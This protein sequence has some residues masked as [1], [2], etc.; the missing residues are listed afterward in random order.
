MSVYGYL[1]TDGAAAPVRGTLVADSPR[2]ARD[3]LREQGLSIHELSDGSSHSSRAMHWRL[4]LL[5]IGRRPDTAGFLRELATLLEVGAPMLESLDTVTRSTRGGFRLTLLRLREEVAAGRS[6]AEAMRDAR[7]AGR[8]AF[9]EVTLAMVG[10]G[11]ESGDVGGVLDQVAEYHERGR[12]FK[13]QLVSALAYPGVVLLVG[14]GVSLFLMSYVVPGLVESLAESGK[15]LPWITVV[16]KGFSD[17]LVRWGWIAGLLLLAGCFGLGLMLRTERGG[18]LADRLVLRL[19]LVGDL[20]RKQAVVRIAFVLSTLMRSGIGFERAVQTAQG[21]ARNRVLRRALSDC[22][23]ALHEGRD[24]GPAL[25]ATGAFPPAVVQVF[26]L[27]Q[28]S[29]RLAEMLDRLAGSY[30]RQVTTLTERLTAVLEPV[31]ILLLAIV[32][33]IIAFATV[34]PIL[35]MGNVL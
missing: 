28:A 6:L 32:V 22:S 31:L 35:E 33:G 17:A 14:T 29:G 9:D 30:D 19:P 24:L 15:P 25:E 3:Q 11:E 21:S 26:D 10:V 2:E 12:R 5:R 4:P 34:L 23:S 27:G 7:V 20:A 1:A 16:V 8:P 13:N 18:L